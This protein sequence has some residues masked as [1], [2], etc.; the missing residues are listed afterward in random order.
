[1]TRFL[2]AL[3]LILIPVI[4]LAQDYTIE[5]FSVRSRITERGEFNVE[6]SIGVRFSEKRHGI[7]RRIPVSG[8]VSTTASEKPIYRDL[9]I[10]DISCNDN[11][12]I[13][14]DGNYL[15]IRLG[16]KDRWVEGYREYIIRYSVRNVVITENT[17]FD[18][19]YW[20]YTGNE[21][22]STI[23]NV[24]FTL[25][26]PRDIVMISNFQ[27]RIYYGYSGS[28]T[29][30]NV[31][32]SVVSVKGDTFTFQF[33][34]QLKMNQGVT[35]QIR[36][37]KGLIQI[38]VFD[39]ILKF[40]KEY[41]PFLLAGL[42]FIVS[43]LIW[44]RWGKDERAP[45]MPEF[46]P[47]K[48]VTPS[49]AQS[50][51]QQRPVF[52]ISAT[53]VDLARR[54]YILIG[55]DKNKPYIEKQ[56]EPDE[57]L[58]R[59]EKLLMEKLFRS[60]YI[61]SNHPNRVYTSSLE[62]SFYNDYDAVVS[63]YSNTFE[64]GGYFEKAGNLWRAFFWFLAFLSVLLLCIAFFTEENPENMYKTAI[65]AVIALA[66]N[67]WFSMIMPKKSVL[68]FKKYQMILGFREFISR[69][70]KDRIRRLCEK[71]PTYFDDTIAFAIVFGMVGVWGKMFD[72][73][74]KEPPNWYRNDDWSAGR[75]F[76][77]SDF[78]HTLQ[79]SMSRFQSAAVS[80]PPSSNG[81][82]G[83]SGGGFG[84][85]SGGGGSWGGSSGGGFGGGGGG[86]W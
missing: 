51:L 21:W 41:Y 2:K 36:L 13:E 37:R 18:E 26:V 61:S 6:E 4:A 17:N 12:S 27:Y 42:L 45:I 75:G 9:D 66:N 35:A 23:S 78:G 39:K 80:T 68:G 65:F 62:Q 85:W 32:N 16:S 43:F 28:A 69:A 55:D 24:S 53:L 84:G 57:S 73:I 30:P 31:S 79:H 83:S 3:I 59:Y 70:E 20:N 54:G 33:K 1:M 63:Q 22:L 86:S 19:L 25:T 74:I 7:Y 56:K 47:P 34:E 50:I 15:Q 8:E 81:S 46:L 14:K 76:Y 67:I 5:S 52:N 58:K 48:D 44:L 82:S 10:Y 71:N 77:Y 72:D 49:E 60:H 38:T 11:M 64:T 29:E 40:W